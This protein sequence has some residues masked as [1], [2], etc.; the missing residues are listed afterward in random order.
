MTA[1]PASTAEK[2][3]AVIAAVAL[4]AAILIGGVATLRSGGPLRV[5]WDRHQAQRRLARRLDQDSVLLGVL[6]HRIGPPT[7]SHVVYEFSDYQCPFCRAADGRVAGW[8]RAK[9]GRAVVF[10]DMPLTQLH[11]VAFPAAIAANCA[12]RQGR[13]ETMH[14]RLMSTTDWETDSNWVRVAGMA[15]VGDTVA[16]K[17]CL[18]DVRV[19]AQIRQSLALGDSLHVTGTPAFL[20][21]GGVFSGVPSSGALDAIP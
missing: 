4:C 21:R 12:A 5:I 18:S 2:V 19:A 1:T 16:F 15:G 14:E 17:A 6:G 9:E 10:L 7:A 20:G 8:I 13:F 11:P 3:Q